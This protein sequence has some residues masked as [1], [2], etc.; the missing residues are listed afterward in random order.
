MNAHTRTRRWLAVVLLVGGL[1]ALSA[2]CIG[3]VE[4]QGDSASGAVFDALT[5]DGGTC[6]VNIKADKELMITDL[7]VVEDARVHNDGP[8]SFEHL[9]EAMTPAGTTPSQF[10]LTWLQQW[11]NVSSINGFPVD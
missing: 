7:S 4:G 6:S 5:A 8:W 10:V 1:S 3:L 11:E 2:A 9:I